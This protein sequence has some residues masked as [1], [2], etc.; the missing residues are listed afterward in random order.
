VTDAVA[1]LRVYT[2]TNAGTESASVDGVDLVSVDNAV[3]SAQNREDN[4][5]VPG[6]NSFEKWLRIKLETPNSH[7]L[8]NFWVERVGDLPDGVVVKMGVTD[9]AATPTASTSTIATNTMSENRRYFFDMGEYDTA[10]DTTRYL[11]LQ[12]Q[13]ALGVSTVSIETQTFEVGWAQAD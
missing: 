11:V 2:G 6:T 5:V 9:T 10:N 1:T 8:S 4:A 13:V 3:N 7:V 12:E